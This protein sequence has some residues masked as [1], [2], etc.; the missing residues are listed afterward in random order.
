M[1]E[2]EPVSPEIS[3]REASV[4]LR[5]LEY[6]VSP[7]EAKHGCVSVSDAVGDGGEGDP[8]LLVN[9]SNE[10]RLAQGVPRFCSI[11][12]PEPKV[13]PE[14]LLFREYQDGQRVQ[15]LSF[16]SR[17][18][19]KF[20]RLNLGSQ[21]LVAEQADRCKTSIPFDYNVRCPSTLLLRNHKKGLV[22]VEAVLGDRESNLVN[23]HVG[24]QRFD[25]LLL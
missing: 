25:D 1:R 16:I 3:P 13:C 15:L 2:V 5:L 18:C 8:V 7:I 22:L 6:R 19:R 12:M 24:P 21:V 4:S 11:Y 10:F 9:F 20:G 14:P 23:G 17:D